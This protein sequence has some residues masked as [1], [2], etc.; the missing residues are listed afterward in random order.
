MLSSSPTLTTTKKLS[1]TPQPSRS[2]TTL[3]TP[4]VVMGDKLDFRISLV[5]KH[6]EKDYLVFH[7]ILK[8][9]QVVPISFQIVDSDT[10]WTS[11]SFNISESPIPN[12]CTQEEINGWKFYMTDKAFFQDL[13][14]DYWDRYLQDKFVYIVSLK[15]TS[16]YQETIALARPPGHC[17]DIVE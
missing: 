10:G 1:P 16:G 6:G 9:S 15:Q 2:P 14:E 12:L 17:M 7:F 3:I 11:F 13:P 5:A 4:T 8:F